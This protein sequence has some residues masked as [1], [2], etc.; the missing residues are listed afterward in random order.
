MSVSQPRFFA[1][2]LLILCVYLAFGFGM[3]AT[4]MP[5][6]DEAYY[7]IP[8]R[9]LYQ[10]GT[11]ATPVIEP[12]GNYLTDINRVTYWEM[13]L[14]LVVQAGWYHVFSESLFSQRSISV[15]SGALGLLCWLAVILRLTRNQAASLLAAALLSVD[16]V[17]HN[18]ISAGRSDS[19][20]FGLGA[21]ALAVL[22]L[23]SEKNL[24]LALLIS[25]ALVVASGLTHPIGGITTL[26]AAIY[27]SVVFLHPRRWK[28]VHWLCI[29]LPYVAGAIGWLL[30][31]LRDVPAFRDQFGGNSAGRLWPLLHPLHALQGEIFGRYLSGFGWSPELSPVH[32]IRLYV[33]AFYLCGLAASFAIAA[34]R[35]A[36]GVRHLQRLFIVM[37]VILFFFE[38]AK[39]SWYLIYVLPY[40]AIFGALMVQHFVRNTRGSNPSHDR[41]GVVFRWLAIGAVT[42]VLIVQAGGLG[43]SIS[44]HHYRTKYLP[45][46]AFLRTHINPH[47]LVMGPAEL[48]LALPFGQVVEDFGF[49]LYSGKTPDYLVLPSNTPLPELCRNKPAVYRHLERM[50]ASDFVRVYDRTPYIILSRRS[51]P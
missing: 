8:G 37:S 1:C 45:A 5:F 43:Y 4:R 49:G 20:S 44:L 41:E 50:I 30:Y 34:I 18:V 12:A 42:A 21:A 48:G 35:T 16:Y 51:S 24:A 28:P 23:L 46:I 40:Y 29:A 39:Q 13:P 27:L 31:I 33:L 10:H 38:G 47:S 17:F 32:R 3:A 26:A 11:T 19:L 7:G 22:L 36:P 9:E 6:C 14:D 25:H 15:L 2:L